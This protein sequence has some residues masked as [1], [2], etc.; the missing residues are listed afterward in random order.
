MDDRPSTRRLTD[1]G[2]IDHA[3]ETAKETAKEAARALRRRYFPL[4]DSLIGMFGR[5][6]RR[7]NL[8]REHIAAADPLKDSGRAAIYV[9]F[10]PDGQVD[11]YVV[12]Q[13][14]ALADAGFRVT[15]VSNSPTLPHDSRA[16]ISAFCKDIIWRFNTGYDFGAYKD[17]IASISN[18]DQLDGLLLMND[19]VYG[20]FRQL[21]EVLSRLDGST[22]DFWGI[23]DSFEYQHHIQTFFMFFFPAA[24]QTP[25]FRRFWARLPYVNHK[26][27]VIRNG[28]VGLSQRLYRAGLRSGVLAP[29]WSV[30]EKM[31]ARLEEMKGNAPPQ[32]Q[33]PGFAR[34][35]SRV[36]GNRAVNPMQ[37]FWD[38]LI[39]DYGCPF[40]KRELIQLNPAGIPFL[41]RWRAV[42]ASRSEYD[43][44][45]I[46][47]H[48][49]RL[50]RR[51]GHDANPAVISP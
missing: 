34:F 30:A 1:I 44:S 27:W 14:S 8:V 38:I 48:L 51:D 35:Q 25:A 37:Y 36:L 4:Q 12:H 26:P 18:L 15:F 42:I 23:A 5:L 3:K 31:K 2:M 7:S 46:E 29:Y 17:G 20:P 11:D 10:D 43:T 24:L 50:D 33:Q 13:V 45:M 19:S 49:R 6:L 32:S 47:R 9:H 16:R 22:A 28:E 39:T 40:I 41:S 21:R